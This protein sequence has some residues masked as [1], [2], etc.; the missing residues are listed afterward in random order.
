M[1]G[2]DALPDDQANLQRAVEKHADARPG[3]E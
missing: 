2:V 3:A 1:G